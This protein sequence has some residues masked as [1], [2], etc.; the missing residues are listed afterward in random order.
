MTDPQFKIRIVFPLLLLVLAS[1]C[2]D[3]PQSLAQDSVDSQIDRVLRGLRPPVTIK[4]RTEVRWTLAERMAALHVPGASI[5]II[6]G[7]RVI[8]AGGFGVKEFGTRDSVTT[9][10]LFQAQSISKPVSATAMLR[11]V[12][13]GQL[14]LDEDVNSYLKSWKVPENNFT[15][16]AKVTLRRIVSHNAGVTVGGFGGYRL[17]DSIPALPQILNGEKPAN[18]AP[19]RVDAVPGSISRYSGGGFLVMQQLLI[20][21][22]GE[23]FPALMKRMVLEPAGMKL[24]TFEQPLPEMRLKE[25]ASG[26]DGKGVV[27]KG[28]W[29]IQPEMAAA[30]LWTTPTELANWV[31]EIANAWGGRR[32]KLLS[33]K[34]ATDM[35]TVQKGQWGLGLVVKGTDQSFA[36]GHSGANLG[37]RADFEMYPAIGKGA[38]VMT[39][40][41]LGSYLIDEIF[42]SIAAEYNWPAHRQS[43]REAVTLTREQLDGLVGM[44]AVAGPFGLVQYEVS[45]EDDRLFAELKGFAPKSEMFAQTADTFFSIYGYS[46]VF[47]RD[48]SGRAVKVKLGG[49]VEAVRK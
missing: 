41:D 23:S 42:E 3:V 28:K 8:W 44:Y 1:P 34:M 6:E 33:K 22:T 16:Q 39:N 38:V 5:A 32:S 26:H 15:N 31:L 47:T 27:M 49:E 46:I 9:S 29:P 37:F 24:S 21:V 18:S 10:T 30:G 40:A 2:F 17:G 12:E 35:L 45:R 11:L 20:D 48:S 4:N 14:S 19:I 7:G 25:A 13:A 43:E 36:F